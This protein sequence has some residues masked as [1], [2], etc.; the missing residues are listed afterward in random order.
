MPYHRELKRM[1]NPMGMKMGK[2]YLARYMPVSVLDRS[3]R[4]QAE[5][6]LEN[7]A[8]MAIRLH[9]EGVRVAIGTDAPNPSL[10]PG[11][12]LHDEIAS[13]Q[14]AG[15]TPIDSLT[16]ATSAG[17]ELL[18]REDIGVVRVGAAADLLCLEGDPSHDVRELGTLR[19]VMIRGA[20]SDL[21]HMHGKLEEA[22]RES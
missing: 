19:R 18:G 1:Q 10:V 2:R 17:G 8:A 22:L 12:S 11:F 16:L 21:E 5:A 9:R 20:W 15:L 3:T 13:F 6:G 4:K 14:A 7:M